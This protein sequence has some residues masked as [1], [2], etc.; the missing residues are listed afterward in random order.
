MVVSEWSANGVAAYD[1]GAEGDPT[2]GTRR[3]FLT[4]LAG[5]EGA[6]FD[7]LTGDFLFSTWN[8]MQPERVV[9]VAG[10]VPIAP[11]K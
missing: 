7:P 9:L 10:F 3:G 5:A 2:S 11:P 1:V 8:A 6:F 4:G